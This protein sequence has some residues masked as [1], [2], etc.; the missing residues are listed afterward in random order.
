M[1]DDVNEANLPEPQ[2][3][4]VEPPAASDESAMA[5]IEL[6][7]VLAMKH[8][9]VFPFTFSPL[10]V[11][12]PM[13][14]A[15]AEAAL[16]SEEKTVLLLTQRDSTVE[17]P[18]AEDLF[19]VGTRAV[20]KRMSRG[21]GV[22]HLLAQGINRVRI[23]SIRKNDNYLVAEV[24]QFP[25]TED[26]ETAREALR[27]AV[28]EDVGRL[29]ELLHPDRSVELGMV[30]DG[31]EDA[32]HLAFMVSSLLELDFEKAQ[33]ILEANT[34]T[35]ALELLHESLLRELQVQE[36]RHQIRTKTMTELDDE[37]RRF[38]LRKQ[39]AAIRDELGEEDPEAAELEE[40]QQKLDESD[41]PEEVR[42]EADREL[43]RLE[44]M[45][46]AASDYQVAR[47]Y[48]ETLTELPWS[49]STDDVIDIQYARQVLDEDH[50]GL[51]EVKDR[52]IEHLAVLK[53]NPEAHSPILCF[54]GLPGV[55]KTSLGQSIA[56]AIGRKFE[57]LSLG[58]L[59]DESELRGHRRTYV[60]AMP[61]R[62]IEG[63]LTF[64]NVLVTGHQA[65]FLR[66]KLSSELPKQHFGISLIYSE[67]E[68][69]TTKC[70]HEREW[71]IS[72]DSLSRCLRRIC[73]LIMGVK[74]FVPIRVGHIRPFFLAE[75]CKF[76]QLRLG[77]IDDEVMFLLVMNEREL[78]P[79]NSEKLVAEPK[80]AAKGQDCVCHLARLDVDHNFLN[81]A[82]LLAVW[83]PHGRSN[84]IA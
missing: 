46:P 83:C 3:T 64:P 56:K 16:A 25:F 71:P 23:R 50:F 8:T 32:V 77:R 20:I 22:V 43:K 4:P 60:G 48:L 41:L 49:E 14:L 72:R 27:L 39:L 51:E 13:S 42:R 81:A 54:L 34:A 38:F 59:H 75:P 69:A 84:H 52:I 18:T 9:A 55:G 40:L 17:E 45:S 65:F 5:L 33:T 37:Q 68:D 73:S 24:E 58:G 78:F 1:T 30:I 31:T 26:G 36:M 47:T 21:D 6:L 82:D 12:R 80:E 15:A 61:G 10:A 53:L 66:K 76:L 2:A 63:L 57:R 67:M 28:R 74:K 79:R 44:R 11:G 29:L 70:Q 62:L 35:Q 19:S 7:P